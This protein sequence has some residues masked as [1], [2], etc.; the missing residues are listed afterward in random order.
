M[1]KLTTFFCE[2]TIGQWPKSIRSMRREEVVLAS[3]RVGF[4]LL[5]HL[6]PYINGTL[7]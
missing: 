5:I 4:T 3:L 2:P 1:N 6:R 7:P